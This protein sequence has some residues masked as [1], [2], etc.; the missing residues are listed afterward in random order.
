MNRKAFTPKQISEQYNL[1]EG[2]LANMRW[3]RTGPRYFK[4][5]KKIMYRP[6]D[7]EAWLF[8]NPVLT[9]DSI[10]EE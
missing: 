6:E 3:S 4:V 1:S 2:T 10:E 8:A 7:V 9:I 5:G